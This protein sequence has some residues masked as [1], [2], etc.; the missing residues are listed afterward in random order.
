MCL[1]LRQLVLS[2]I[3]YPV[4]CELVSNAVGDYAKTL[5]F[6][7][8]GRLAGQPASKVGLSDEMQFCRCLPALPMREP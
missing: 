7:K 4:M 3:R 2:S 6:E 8:C 1:R 5:D